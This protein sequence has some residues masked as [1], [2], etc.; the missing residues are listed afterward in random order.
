MALLLKK[1]YLRNEY[2]NVYAR[3]ELVSINNED[4][5]VL[6]HFWNEDKTEIIHSWNYNIHFNKKAEPNLYTYCYDELK[7]LD[8]FFDAEDI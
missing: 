4:A 6:V 5:N 7:K 3:I 2:D 8:E 1:Y